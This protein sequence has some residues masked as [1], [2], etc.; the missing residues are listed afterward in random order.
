MT[1]AGELVECWWA[2]TRSQA[3]VGE[4]RNKV[5]ENDPDSGRFGEVPLRV[6]PMFATITALRAGSSYP[7]ASGHITASTSVTDPYQHKLG[8]N[9]AIT[10]GLLRDFSSLLSPPANGSVIYLAE[11]RDRGRGRQAGS[12]D[13]AGFTP[14]GGT[15]GR[16][17]THAARRSS[18]RRA[19]PLGRPTR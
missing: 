9:S 6:H 11:S 5:A 1:S 10:T 4:S 7:R 8:I 14:T 16:P 12:R 19:T 17:K 2:L 13:D 15:T 18:P 3:K